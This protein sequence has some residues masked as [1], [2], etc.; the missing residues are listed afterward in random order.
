MN[1]LIQEFKFT[2]RIYTSDNSDKLPALLLV[3]KDMFENLYENAEFLS[4]NEPLRAKLK[5]RGQSFLQISILKAVYL[6]KHVEEYYDRARKRSIRADPELRR[7]KHQTLEVIQKAKEA[8]FKIYREKPV[9]P[10]PLEELIK[11]PAPY[12]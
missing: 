1:E 2:K 10:E 4:T 8:L 11:L 3:I 9:E 5:L 7:I 12:M 6:S